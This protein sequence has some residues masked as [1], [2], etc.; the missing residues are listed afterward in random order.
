MTNSFSKLAGID[1]TSHASFY[2]QLPKT[3]EYLSSTFT[4]VNDNDDSLSFQRREFEDH[5]SLKLKSAKSATKVYE[6]NGYSIVGDGTTAQLTGLLTGSLENNLP[7]GK[8][9]NDIKFLTFYSKSQSEES[10][11]H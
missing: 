6:M 5:H 7:D 11:R 4:F 8:I 9:S 3:I 10:G 1:S 2:R